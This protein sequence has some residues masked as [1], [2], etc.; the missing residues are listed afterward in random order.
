MYGGRDDPLRK[1][2]PG[3]PSRGRSARAWNAMIDAARYVQG[4]LR[5]GLGAQEMEGLSPN[6]GLALVQN[7][8]GVDLPAYSVLAIGAPLILPAAELSQFQLEP[9]FAGI[10]PAAPPD[11]A[12]FIVT[13][14]PIAQQLLGRAVITGAVACQVNVTSLLHGFAVPIAGNSD[15]LQSSASPGGA[16][17]LTQPT[18]TGLQWLYV[19]LGRC[20]AGNFAAISGGSSQPSPSCTC[21]AAIAVCLTWNSSSIAGFPAIVTLVLGTNCLW[22]GSFTANGG[23]WGFAFGLGSTFNGMGNFGLNATHWYVFLGSGA[24]DLSPWI[25]DLG[26]T[27]DCQSSLS[28]SIANNSATIVAGACGG[29]GGGGG[30]SVV[31]HGTYGATN[32][33]SLTTPNIPV[34]LGSEL[35]VY[36]GVRLPDTTPAGYQLVV[37]YNGVQLNEVNFAA[38]DDGSFIAQAHVQGAYI[39]SSFGSTNAPIVVTATLNGNPLTVN[40]LVVAVEEVDGVQN[41]GTNNGFDHGHAGASNSAS[42]TADSGSFTTTR[43]ASEYVFAA[44]VTLGPNTDAA[45]VWQNGWSMGQMIGTANVFL[46]T[47]G[48]IVAAIGTYD[49]QLASMTSRAWACY[50]QSTW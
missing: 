1:V 36:V 34:T 10:W 39:D 21:A 7:S 22:E 2:R 38:C 4:E 17:I 6:P 5:A 15:H 32:A 41:N 35:L 14:D 25:I 23:L 13:L 8:T 44:A 28:G 37:S 31:E 49:G 48:K 46:R 27:W 30:L 42:T 33:S 3:E 26:P 18:Q 40:D 24:W 45:G 11:L 47:G 43:A 19:A 50:A 29:G 9:A 16:V 20:C 12:R